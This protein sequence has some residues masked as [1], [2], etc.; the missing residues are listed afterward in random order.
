MPDLKDIET[1]CVCDVIF[2]VH[3]NGRAIERVAGEIIKELNYHSKS[4]TFFFPS[5]TLLSEQPS[6]IV[7]IMM[8]LCELGHHLT[9]LPV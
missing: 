7:K 3:K 2:L 1:L 4:A 9:R 5:L 6:N 8:I